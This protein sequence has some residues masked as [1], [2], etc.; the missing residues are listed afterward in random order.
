M[1]LILCD[2]RMLS[3]LSTATLGNSKSVI[4]HEI[5]FINRNNFYLILKSR[6]MQWDKTILSFLSVSMPSLCA[7][8]Y[9]YLHKVSISC[10]DATLTFPIISASYAM[11]YSLLSEVEIVLSE[12]RVSCCLYLAEYFLNPLRSFENF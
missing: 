2:M 10:K 4:E 12:E 5:I 6:G 8:T 3:L 1:D 9:M 11:K 7:G